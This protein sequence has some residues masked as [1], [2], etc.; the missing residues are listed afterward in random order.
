MALYVSGWSMVAFLEK[1]PGMTP[2][3]YKAIVAKAPPDEDMDMDEGG[4]HSHGDSDAHAHDAAAMGGM[5]MS[6][7]GAASAPSPATVGS[8]GTKP[9]GDGHTHP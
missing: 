8:V 5:D 3:E 7:Q 4:S 9:L 2:A 6:G 1:L